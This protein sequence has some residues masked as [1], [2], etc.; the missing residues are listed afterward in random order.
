MDFKKI[1][2]LLDRAEKVQ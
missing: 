1:L 2:S